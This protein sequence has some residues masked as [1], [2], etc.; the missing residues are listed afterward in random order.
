MLSKASQDLNSFLIVTSKDELIVMGL[1]E[2][3]DKLC[4]CDVKVT[5]A[6]GN[7]YMVKIS[8]HSVMGK[9]NV[10]WGEGDHGRYAS[11]YRWLGDTV[12]A[13]LSHPNPCLLVI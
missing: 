12:L 3:G 10:K 5:G 7:G 13:S 8:L 11:N 6:G 4:G 9:L 2:T 1:S